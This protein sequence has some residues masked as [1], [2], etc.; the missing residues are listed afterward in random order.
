MPIRLRNSHSV[1]LVIVLAMFTAVA[2]PLWAQKDAGAIVGVVRDSSGAVVANAK[3]VVE[4]VDRGLE[5]DRV[6]Q[7]AGRVRGQPAQDRTIQRQRREG[8]I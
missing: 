6:H 7:R 3:V 5:I 4:D 8:R 2:T 1:L